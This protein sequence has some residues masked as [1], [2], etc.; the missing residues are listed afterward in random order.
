[1]EE[2]AGDEDKETMAQEVVSAATAVELKLRRC[3][4]TM[5]QR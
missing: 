1:L 3:Q 4:E 2:V 5:D